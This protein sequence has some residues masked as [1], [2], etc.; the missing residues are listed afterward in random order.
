MSYT[1]LVSFVL[2]ALC[3][4]VLVRT[5]L[6]IQQSIHSVLFIMSACSPYYALSY[7]LLQSDSSASLLEEIF[8]FLSQRRHH[9]ASAEQ[10][11]LLSVFLNLFVRVLVGRESKR[12]RALCSLK[13]SASFSLQQSSIE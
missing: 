10:R 8:E 4:Y 2:S 7:A 3:F 9:Q 1:S 13:Q 12:E 5:T 11:A 6:T